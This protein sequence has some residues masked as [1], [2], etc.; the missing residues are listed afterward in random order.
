VWLRRRATLL[1]IADIAALADVTHRHGA[2]LVVDNTFATPYLQT[3]LTLG[4]D[5]V[6]HS[7]TKYSEALRRNR[8]DA[9]H[10]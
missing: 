5:V 6:M 10:Q 7:T 4:A 3:P 8:R 1:R 9:R 2:T